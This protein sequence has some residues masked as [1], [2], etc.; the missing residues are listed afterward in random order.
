[1]SEGRINGNLNLSRALGNL[2]YK[3]FKEGNEK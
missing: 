1:M 3:Q 2:E